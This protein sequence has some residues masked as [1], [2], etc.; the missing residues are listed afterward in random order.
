MTISSDNQGN[1]PGTNT[2]IKQASLENWVRVPGVGNKIL[3]FLKAKDVI[4][5]ITASMKYYSLSSSD[6]FYKSF[7]DI[8]GH[9]YIKFV[10]GR[11]RTLKKL[12][13]SERYLRI[14]NTCTGACIAGGAALASYNLFPTNDP[15]LFMPLQMAAGFG[16]PT[17]KLGLGK[18][19][20][21]IALGA[22]AGAVSSY[23]LVSMCES[24][25]ILGEGAKEDATLISHTSIIGAA[26]G[27]LVFN[28]IHGIHSRKMKF[29]SLGRLL[30]D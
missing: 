4:N 12:K 5:I 29:P 28:R 9:M 15:K 27:G 10:N 26:I 17:Y 8:N 7:K 19:V 1:T 18:K 25:G 23:A 14:L 16:V 6:F 30:G 22:I 11:S 24:F 13:D 20:V 3:E 2:L 21:P